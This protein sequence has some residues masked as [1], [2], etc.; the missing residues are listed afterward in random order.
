LHCGRVEK[1]F[2]ISVLQELN[3]RAEEPDTLPDGCLSRIVG[4]VD[5]GARVIEVWES[6]DHARKFSEEHGP[7]IGELKIPPPDR[8][9]A[10]ETSVYMAQ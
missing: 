2:D 10:F 1:D 8:V 6:P 5:T 9:A 3:E 4:T 7:A